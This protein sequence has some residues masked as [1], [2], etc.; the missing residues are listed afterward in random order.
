MVRVEHPQFGDFCPFGGGA[1]PP[2]TLFVVRRWTYFGHACSDMPAWP[3]LAGLHP[4]SP[5]VGR[6]QRLMDQRDL[7]V[8]ALV[9]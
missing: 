2:Q 6:W 7:R 8:A 5:Q 1:D 4:K 9:Y 3:L